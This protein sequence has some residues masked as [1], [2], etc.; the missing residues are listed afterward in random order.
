MIDDKTTINTS[1]ATI[2][3]SSVTS[4]GG[5]Y[6]G[7]AV[8]GSASQYIFGNTS[9]FDT[10]SNFDGTF[11]F[12]TQGVF[13]STNV[14][15]YKF[16]AVSITNV[17]KLTTT[18]GPLDVALIGVNSINDSGGDW[19][20]DSL[21]SL[22]L[23][24]VN[25]PINFSGSA[26][27]KAAQNS[28][29][30]FLQL[31]SRG[32]NA[33]ISIGKNISLPGASLLVNSEGDVT[34][35]A[36][37][38]LTLNNGAFFVKGNINFGDPVTATELVLNAGGT[39]TFVKPPSIGSLYASADSLILQDNLVVKT[40]G[41]LSIGAGGITA[42]KDKNLT[43]LDQVNSQGDISVSD[44]SAN[45]GINALGALLTGNLTA[46]HTVSAPSIAFG[47]GINYDGGS[48]SALLTSNGGNGGSL[49]ILADSVLFDTDG[50]NG[51]S[52][53]GGDG[54]S[55]LGS[56][57][58]NGGTLNVG[59]SAKPI[60]GPITVNKP[61]SATTGA[62]GG[63]LASTGGNGGTVSMVS[64]DTITVNST[65]KVS[66][67]SGSAMSTKG[68]NISLT[69]NKTSGA[70]ISVTNSG[71]LLSLLSSAASGKG[72][73]ITFTS[74]GGD[75]N[76]NNGGV[77]ADKGIVD[78]RNNG[79]AS[80][81]VNLTNATLSASTV[82]VGAFGSNGQLII[83]GANISADTAIKL[84]ANGSN[85]TVL[86]AA[87]TA[88]NGNSVKSIAGNTVTIANG[89]TV[90]IGGSQ[91]A[92]VYTNNANYTGSG[93][94]GSTSGKFTGSGATTSPLKNAPAF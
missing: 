70:A 26:Q 48:A 29:F 57:G 38:N 46:A 54:T 75:I 32:A 41:L 55:L 86:F 39:I 50:I 16:T 56:T 42:A 31:Y 72:G 90:T 67:S 17:P 2:T 77:R 64:N 5:I 94:N 91:P 44:L 74:A 8:D 13:P 60:T 61:I 18:G 4:A 6:H 66:E 76:I 58:G 83:N 82:K 80:G 68:G 62:N 49:T 20:L 87:D 53:N 47:K 30:Q 15:V 1:A 84:Y 45:I 93:G 52:L 35:A 73:T 27:L 88:L 7:Q 85:G 79:T 3:R 89:K 19:A 40:G 43:G 28:G 25:G 71:Q 11:G 65:V 12:G 23:G 34:S 63:L 36:S 10:N 92:T 9:A 24:T 81:A 78:I 37:A 21:N 14:A 22:F 69:S 59:T 51:A 33:G